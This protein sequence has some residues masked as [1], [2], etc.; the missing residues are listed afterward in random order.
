MIF[1]QKENKEIT[2]MLTHNGVSINQSIY[3]SIYLSI[4]QYIYMYVCMYV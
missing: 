4:Y 2:E 3:L 1:F